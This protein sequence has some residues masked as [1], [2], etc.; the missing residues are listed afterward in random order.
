MK[1]AKSFKLIFLSVAF[2]FSLLL[3]ALTLN[4]GGVDG[5]VKANY[6]TGTSNYFT[7]SAGVSYE[8]DSLVISALDGQDLS[9]VNPLVVSDFGMEVVVPSEAKS[10]ELA[11]KSNSFVLH[12]NQKVDGQTT[13]YDKEITNKIIVTISG[14]VATAKLNDGDLAENIAITDNKIIFNVSVRDNIL[15]A[16]VNGKDLS[17]SLNDNDE[18]DE[19]YKIA[20]NEKSVGYVSLKFGV[21]GEEAKAFDISY[22][23]QS[24]NGVID[25]KQTFNLVDDDIV[26]AIP[27][28]VVD[29]ELYTSDNVIKVRDGEEITATLYAY[30]IYEKVKSSDLYLDHSTNGKA[31]INDLIIGESKPK[32]LILNKDINSNV[33]EEIIAVVYGDEKTL[34][35]EIAITVID[36]DYNTGNDAPIYNATES[37]LNAFMDAL[38]KATKIGDN[39][40]SLGKSIDIPSLKDFV[41]YEYV[42]YEKLKYTVYVNSPNDENKT[43]STMKIRVDVPG[44]YKFYVMFYDGDNTMESPIDNE[45]IMKGGLADCVFS[46]KI[47]D[48]APLVVEANKET[49]GTNGYVG[50]R[51][52]AVPFKIEAESYSPTYSLWYNPTE[53]AT[54]ETEGWV[55]VLKKSE[56]TSTYDDEKETFTKEEIETINYDGRLVFT[57][58]K[59]GTYRIDCE[60]SKGLSVYEDADSYFIKVTDVKLKVKPQ[61]QWVKNNMVS[62]IF[63]SIGTA[64]LIGIL[65]LLFIKPKERT[66]RIVDED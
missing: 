45:D 7:T 52:S 11:I 15:S 22:I 53:D 8:R 20:G 60:V 16:N 63:L 26:P 23:D 12:G 42:P 41:D 10:L 30:S 35:G 50:V 34:A 48:N 21:E 29:S 18:F 38:V 57:P 19:Y 17:F 55:K 25:H 13:T 51:Y 1:K 64:C 40:V 24:V 58:V 5:V 62:I 46:F 36:K 47:E 9:I 32:T 39:Y 2:C 61:N 27:E 6:K 4:N 3:G 56:L 33:T 49:A 37:A 59:V 44:E 43:S 14:G 66:E 54:F 65:I 28:V 31:E